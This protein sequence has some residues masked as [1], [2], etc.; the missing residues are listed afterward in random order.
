MKSTQIHLKCYLSPEFN[1]NPIDSR[2][3]DSFKVYEPN[4]TNTKHNEKRFWFLSEILLVFWIKNGM[5]FWEWISFSILILPYCNCFQSYV[6]IHYAAKK[7]TKSIAWKRRT[8]V[9]T[10]YRCHKLIIQLLDDF[11]GGE[12][13]KIKHIVNLSIDA[14]SSC[15]SFFQPKFIPYA[16]N[17]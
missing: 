3:I 5:L 9:M 1:Q 13:I 12:E 15:N 17:G 6:F 11:D 10:C 2:Q 14:W 7:K 8:L 4:K 16:Y